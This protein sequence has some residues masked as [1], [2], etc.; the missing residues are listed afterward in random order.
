MFYWRPQ[1]EISFG[2]EFIPLNYNYFE[3]QM[4]R[5]ITEIYSYLEI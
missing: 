5:Q 3:L 1:A 2:L 4:R